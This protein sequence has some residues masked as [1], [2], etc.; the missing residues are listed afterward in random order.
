MTCN[1]LESRPDIERLD[2]ELAARVAEACAAHERLLA[3]RVAH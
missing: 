3:R 1:S 2:A